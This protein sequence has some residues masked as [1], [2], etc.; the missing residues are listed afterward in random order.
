MEI[1]RKKL[2][3]LFAMVSMLIAGSGLMALSVNAAVPDR[4]ARAFISVAPNVLG[5]GQTAT[6]NAW[7]WPSPSGPTFFART[8][9][10]ASG[11]YAEYRNVTVTF[12]R[13]DGSKDTF[14]PTHPALDT[15]RA[16]LPCGDIYFFYKPTQAGTWS[17]VLS[18]P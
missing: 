13:P 18:F 11:M 5:V 2:F 9:D 8:P 12:T 16:T 3:A 14:M 1:S 6:V 15:P 10:P 17:V 4:D 7:I